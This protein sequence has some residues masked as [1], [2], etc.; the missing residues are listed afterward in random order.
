MP[1]TRRRSR[2]L[3]PLTA[4][5]ALVLTAAVV[6]SAAAADVT[7]TIAEV[8]GT[9]SQSTMI[10]ATVT[11]E[12]V[13]VGDYRTGGFRG[14]SIQAE[15]SGGA[16]DATP[17]ASDGIFVF[18]GTAN[19]VP[20]AIPMAVGDLVRVTGPVG[21]FLTST[22]AMGQSFVTQ[23][24]AT[25]TG[26]VEVLGAPA[27]PP[28]PTALPDTVVG[29]AREPFENML[30][31]PTGDYL[32]A[33]FHEL[34]RFGS[35]WLSAGTAPLVKATAVERP[36][37]AADAIAASN[38]ARR[39]VLDDGVSS[40]N[41][42]PQPYVDPADEVRTGDVAAFDVPVVLSEGFGLWRFQ[43]QTPVSGATPADAKVSFVERNARPAVAAVGGDLTVAAFNVLNY[44]TTL[45]ARGAETPEEFAIQKAKIVAAIT[46]LD[47]DVVAL[48]E[49]ENAIMFGGATPDVALADLVDGLNA[50]AGSSVWGY[51]PTPTSLYGAGAPATDE[52]MSAIIY[53]S[54]VVT[55]VG[56]SVA[57]V[58]ETV[59]DIAREPIAQAFTTADGDPFVVIANHFKSKSGTGT[60]PADGQGFFNPERVEQATALVAFAD[61]V[62]TAAG[63]TD[64]ALL[65]DFNAYAQEDPIATI[66]AAGYTDV[67][68]AAPAEHS[69]TFNGE[70]GSLD[71]ALLSASFVERM[72]GAEVWD[73]NA[74]EW[75]GYEYWGAA[76]A[77]EAT[78][79]YRASDHDP[80]RVGITA[81]T[82]PVTI[83]L[84]GIND[85]HGRL[86]AGGVVAGAAVLAGYVDAARAA[87]PNTVFFSAGDSIGASTF[88]SFIQQDD[89]TIAALNAMG[90]EVTALGNHEFDQ[91]RVDL[92]DRVLP[93]SDFPYLGANVYD[94]V[95]GL[96]AY[97]DSFVTEV[98]GVSV[99]FIGAVTAELPSLV[100]PAGIASL[101]VKPVLPEVNRVAADLTDGDAANG[102]ADVIV[103][104]VHEGAATA[105]PA[106]ATD[107]SGFGQIVTGASPE[108][109]V[110]YSG[111]THQRYAHLV[112]VDGWTAGLSR[113]VV[114]AGQYG[115]AIGRV[116]LTVDRES[117]E[118]L[119]NAAVVTSLAGSATPDPEVAA[120]VADATAVADVLGSVSLGQIAADL[121]RARTVAGSENR[122][123]ESTLGNVVADAQ[124]WATS[125]LG[126][127]IAF[128]N[129]GGLRA[130]LTY[131]SSGATD[132][133][134]NLTYKEAATVQPFANTLVTMSLTGAQVVSVLEEQWQPAGA[135]RPFLKLGVAGLTYTY[136]PTGAAGGRITEVMVGDTPLDLAASYT[137]VVN[138]FLSSGGDNFVTFA[139]GTDR[140]DSG[141]VDLQAFVD[142][143]D[144]HTPIGPDLA[145]RAVGVQL[146]DVPTDGYLPGDTVTVNL[147]S[148][149]FSGGE[150][151][152]TEVTLTAG[153]S[154]LGTFPIDPTIV[155]ATDEVGRA[156]VTF[157]VPQGLAG[158]S[159]V[160]EVSTASGTTSSFAIPLAE[161]AVPTCTVDYSAVRLGRNFLA[162]VRVSNDTATTVRGWTL[163][164]TY[165]Q[166]EKANAGIGATVRQ[167]GTLVTARS[168]GLTST[169]R[170]GRT[171]SFAVIG[172]A[173]NGI[174]TPTGFALDGLPCAVTP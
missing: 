41:P 79:V 146:V 118:V 132:P 114:Q 3:I 60:E 95:T 170:P 113:P 1:T 106:T 121:N 92:D 103:L 51:V 44:F 69:Y 165:A 4:T 13:V 111:H 74:D 142:Y 90:L 162:G 7:H 108:I 107:G 89:P 27:D 34:D 20:A 87:N 38:A 127:Q 153:G 55:R 12:G 84:L 36:G 134:G 23:V 93:A 40:Q 173:P 160:V 143:V 130:N 155:D 98:D 45:A 174:G 10:G 32:V 66:T 135:Q 97:D 67:M 88:T 58:D 64:V 100:T 122:G 73:I 50:A 126:T 164:W 8:Q 151:Q 81:S 31:A 104:L 144:A 123:G 18:L 9:A 96:P 149:L 169:I 30:V 57:D 157:A 76:A 163:T 49:I 24:S 154:T 115:E 15:G 105:D 101:E 33:S 158:E 2:R 112:P 86:E 161:V 171:V 53:R 52:I 65:G 78:S 119:S 28:V 133:D 120:I 138:S 11:V 54:D 116:T 150:A 43:P 5:A 172:K 109:D 166:G 14:I 6:P 152:A 21:D 48:Q 85:F 102:E 145:Q 75:S 62:A 83:D 168:T 139:A 140:A 71:H 137:V 16:T 29:T 148:L 141:R 125:A 42:I 70:L 110:I 91:G 117:G 80:I 131:A 19:S 46:A 59:W 77:V 61:E 159:L 25:A 94:R 124:L 17:G 47:A 136:D 167:S 72:T 35:V 99:G 128:M 63:T 37:P 22:A 129:P 147:S 39:I 26:A 56:E 156:A 82:P 68:A